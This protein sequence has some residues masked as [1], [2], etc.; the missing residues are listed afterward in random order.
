[1]GGLGFF[2]SSGTGWWPM[3]ADVL[4]CFADLK[5]ATYVP[6]ACNVG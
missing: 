2:L 4:K 6:W 3:I 1:M 5:H